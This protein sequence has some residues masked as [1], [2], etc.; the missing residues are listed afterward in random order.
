MIYFIF[1]KNKY[2]EKFYVL[3]LFIYFLFECM[4]KVIIECMY[5]VII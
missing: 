4:Y 2:R 1:F 3:I 5:K